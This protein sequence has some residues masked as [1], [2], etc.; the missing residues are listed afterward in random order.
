MAVL[1]KFLNYFKEKTPAP[2]EK[3]LVKETESAEVVKVKQKEYEA[4]MQNIKMTEAQKYFQDSFFVDR[5][6][7]RLRERAEEQSIQARSR[8]PGIRD[9]LH[10]YEGSSRP[11]P[12]KE[13]IGVITLDS[14]QIQD[15]YQEAKRCVV[16]DQPFYFSILKEDEFSVFFSQ[17]Y[18]AREEN[19]YFKMSFVSAVGMVEV[20]CHVV[21]I[22]IDDEDNMVSF[23]RVKSV[24]G[25][26][27]LF[28]GK[29][30]KFER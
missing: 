12:E 1:K 19:R 26:G 28:E 11:I 8:Y 9:L 25:H 22:K 4:L 24:A 10:T 13:T 17:Y 6:Q 16:F 30:R 21:H 14:D 29:E 7:R 2:E 27:K 23:E 3:K 20:S 5:E 15:L 18:E